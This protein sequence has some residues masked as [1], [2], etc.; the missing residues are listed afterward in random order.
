MDNHSN[1]SVRAAVI[2]AVLQHPDLTFAEIAE[3]HDVK[4]HEVACWAHQEGVYRRQRRK[5]TSLLPEPKELGWDV[6]IRQLEE[7]LAEARRQHA[8]TEIRFEREGSK[9]AVYGLGAQPLIA[10]YKDWLRFLRNN[11]AA[12]LREFIQTQFGNTNGN[13]SVQ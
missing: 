8:L 13:G 11:G 10:D 7:Q 1:G 4:P 5:R 12:K 6:K 2:Q 3:L 9:V